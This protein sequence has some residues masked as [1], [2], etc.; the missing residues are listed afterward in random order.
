MDEN[1]KT[2]IYSPGEMVRLGKLDVALRKAQAL[3]REAYKIV[4]ET[5]REHGKAWNST[6]P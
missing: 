6:L 3:V 1:N 5:D 2:E 4:E